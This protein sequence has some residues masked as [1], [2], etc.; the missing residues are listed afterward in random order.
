MRRTRWLLGFLGLLA[1]VA[2]GCGDDGASTGGVGGSG[3]S[4]GGEAGPLV[5]ETDK[6]PVEGGLV[7]SSRVFFGIPYAAPPVGDLRWRPP[8]PHDA[9]TEVLPAIQRKPACSQ[10]SVLTHVYDDN[11]VEDCLTLNVWTP[12][13][14]LDEPRP[15]LV[16]IHGGAFVLGQSAE[17][18]YDGQILSE[19]TG[20]VVVTVNYRLGPLGFLALPELDAEDPS[21]PSTGSYGL[22]DQRAA[23]EWVK[24]NIA[25]FGGDP[26]R[27]TLFGES[28]GGIS[29]CFHMVSPPSEGLFHRAIIESGPCDTA[30]PKADAMAQGEEFVAA[31]GCDTDADRLACL[32][33]KDTQAIIDAL[34]VSNDFIFADGPNW[35]PIVDGY[36]IPDT[37][38]N[39]FASGNF[40]DVP[41]I[42]GANS[43][44]GS[45]F[46]RLAGKTGIVPDEAAF[47]SLAE[48][49]VPEHGAEIV[50]AYPTAEFGTAQA[51]A[52]AA[53]G[54][55]GF[56]C[57]T[58]RFVRALGAAGG[59]AYLY[60][61]TH[62]P[63]NT[64][65]SDLG[66]Y[67]SGEVR[68]VFGNPA[69]LVPSML[70]EDERTFSESIMGYWSR[71]AAN[72]DPN[73][74]GALEWPVYKS[75]T[76]EAM[77]LDFEQSVEAGVRADTCDF[78]DEV[79]PGSL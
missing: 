66:A 49:L 7:G 11:T 22:E 26:S 2:V 30:T 6:G 18:A 59:S 52:E 54:D 20:S 10:T 51:A 27:V 34:P 55:A 39:L 76:D 29:T 67:H 47:E 33:A 9:W 74:N 69:Q 5:V 63:E 40:Y 77:I 53:F 50:A 43:D 42:A 79:F 62:A 41:T 44:E 46:F 15:V 23:L 36:N 14:V 17:P 4:G 32:R 38:T 73:G 68:Y 12:S 8:A 58:R 71:H 28:A 21:H 1:S 13:S 35:F 60:H 31:L 56:V 45:L 75:A 61:F 78:W 57:P 48:Q 25:A 19:T 24:A 16:W 64:L 65:F 37:P 70:T 3:G 72:G